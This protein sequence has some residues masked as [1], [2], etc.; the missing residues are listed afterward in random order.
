M[1][2]NYTDE[3]RKR[4]NSNEIQIKR[5]TEKMRKNKGK[6]LLWYQKKGEK[7]TKIEK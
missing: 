4:E 1:K 5:E 6:I 2:S 3:K 7:E